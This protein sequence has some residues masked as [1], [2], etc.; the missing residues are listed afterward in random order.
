M[1]AGKALTKVGA[2]EKGA[3]AAKLEITAL[4]RPLLPPESLYQPP[5]APAPAALLA[6]VLFR[7]SIGSGLPAC[8]ALKCLC[9]LQQRI[10]TCVS[11]TSRHQ[12]LGKHLSCALIGLVML[13]LW[14]VPFLVL[15]PG[16][17]CK[18]YQKLC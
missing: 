13:V 15:M 14:Q 4:D 6:L 8:A 9:A 3:V 12:L 11:N 1:G 2:Q 18:Q 10:C 5:P 17:M 7:A 16:L